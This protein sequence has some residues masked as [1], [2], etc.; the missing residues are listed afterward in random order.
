MP[1]GGVIELAPPMPNMPTTLVPGTVVVI[2]GATI[3]VVAVPVTA[4]P[5]AS[6]GAAV[7]TPL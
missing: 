6:M 4:P 7:F 3:E 5:C 2:E 1:G